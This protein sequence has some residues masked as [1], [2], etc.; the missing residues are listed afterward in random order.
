MSKIFPR[1]NN[2]TLFSVCI[3]KEQNRSISKHIYVFL[4]IYKDIQLINQRKISK[5]TKYI[6]F[7]KYQF[8]LLKR[9]LPIFFTYMAMRIRDIVR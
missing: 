5:L 7:Q 2:A 3:S 4:K 9:A 6:C 1:K 8:F